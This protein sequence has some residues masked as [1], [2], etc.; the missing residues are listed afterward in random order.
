ME[1]INNGL[2]QQERFGRNV[3][4]LI[5]FMRHGE[6][7]KDLQLLDL[8]R[9][10]TKR[11]AVESG[12]KQDDF[13]AVKAIGS[14]AS[15]IKEDIKMG[16][17]LETTDIYATEIAGDEKFKTRVNDILSYEKLVSPRP[18]NHTEIYNK[19]L[20]DNFDELADAEKIVAAK[21]AQMATVNYLIGLS[22]PEAVQ[23]KKEIA[24]SFAYVVKHYQAMAK[25]LNSGSKVLLPAGTHGGTMEFLLQQ[26]LVVK[27]GDKGKIGFNDIKEIGGEFDPSDSYN[28][29]I[30]TDDNGEFKELK[31]SFDNQDRPQEEMF[32]DPDKVNELAEFYELLHKSE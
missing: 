8:G 32:L 18:Y 11:K 2:E 20:P 13:D 25:K 17:A 27:N 28:V 23:Y 15:P 26:A 9:D 24:G 30:Q 19:N 22:T 7:G 5:K 16:R 6:R 12:I 21:K 29:D 31:I 1:R 10:I 3:K 4:I 14:N